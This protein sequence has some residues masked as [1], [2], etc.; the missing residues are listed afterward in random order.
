M[1]SYA[2][3]RNYKRAPAEH[4]TNFVVFRSCL[5]ASSVYYFSETGRAFQESF[6]VFNLCV[7]S[8][9]EEHARSVLEGSE[10]VHCEKFIMQKLQS[11]LSLLLREEVYVSAPRGSGPIAAEAWWKLSLLGS[12]VEL[13]PQ[14][15]SLYQNNL[16]P[17]TEIDVFGD[18]NEN[19]S[20]ELSLATGLLASVGLTQFG[21]L[22]DIAI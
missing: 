12:Q 19:V 21:D 7:I 20:T 11:H 14:A 5:F 16:I 10:C 6:Q 18:D 9:G 1:T 3:A 4:I 2:G 22:H 8:L 15:R 13:W 17:I